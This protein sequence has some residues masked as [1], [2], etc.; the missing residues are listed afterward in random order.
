MWEG[1]AEGPHA[2]CEAAK[3]IGI[4]C[5]T[6]VFSVNLWQSFMLVAMLSTL[7]LLAYF[8]GRFRRLDTHKMLFGVSA[9]YRALDERKVLKLHPSQMAKMLG[10]QKWLNLGA[11]TLAKKLNESY[12][13]QYFIV[14]F[15]EA[16]RKL[17]RGEAKLVPIW[18][19]TQEGE[20]RIDLET[21]RAL[22]LGSNSTQDDNTPNT[23]GVTGSFDMFVRAV[24][25]WDIRHWIFHPD[26]EIRIGLRVAAFIA[27]L[28]YL[29]SVNTGLKFL[30]RAPS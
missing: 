4:E 6:T 13:K 1:L 20:V 3:T 27:A 23:V 21:M 5:S 18:Q 24:R 2:A 28:E 9:P 14:E 7:M 29:P 25:W 19:Q 8:I 10:H 16:G 26:R 17:Y 12:S 30:L 22:K 11:A 15:R